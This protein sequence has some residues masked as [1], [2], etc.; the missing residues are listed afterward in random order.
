MIQCHACG[1]AN[2]GESNF[3]RFCGARFVQMEKQ[4]EYDDVVPPRPYVWKTDEFEISKAKQRKTEQFTFNEPTGMTAPVQNH[5]FQTQQL[6]Y[7]KPYGIANNYNC[8]RCKN[9]VAPRLERKI[10]NAGWIVFAV[11]LVTPLFP[12]CWIGFFI[13]EDISV[14]PVCQYRIN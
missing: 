11:L 1:Q 12:F 3:C 5:P 2:S 10:S 7:Q 14:C 6:V 8:P 9:N 4:T 13:K